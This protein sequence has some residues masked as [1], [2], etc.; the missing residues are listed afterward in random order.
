[1]IF[2]GVGVKH[3][4]GLYS[5]IKKCFRFRK[6]KNKF[7]ANFVKNCKKKKKKLNV[8]VSNPHAC[9]FHFCYQTFDY[10]GLLLLFTFALKCIWTQNAMICNQGIL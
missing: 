10:L 2:L 9:L 8:L 1:M 5:A 6:N 7:F 3:F 4:Q